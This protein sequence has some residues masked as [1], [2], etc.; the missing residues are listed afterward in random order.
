MPRNHD[1]KLAYIL[2]FAAILVAAN[3]FAI[4]QTAPLL[5]LSASPEL[6][7]AGDTIKITAEPTNFT[8]TST[9]FTWFKNDERLTAASGLGKNTL[10]VATDPDGA[11]LIR[12]RLEVNPGKGF[13]SGTEAL[14][15]YT[16]APPSPGNDIIGGIASDFTLEASNQSPDVGE[17][18]SAEVITFAFDKNAANYQWYINGA[19]DRAQSG[20]GRFRISLAAPAEGAA[21]TVRVDVTAPGG[22]TRSKSVIVQTASAPFYWWAD[23][24]TPYWYKG[25]ALP[26]IGGLVTVMALPNVRGP[27]QLSYQWQIND[28]IASQVSGAGRQT[29]SFRLAVPVEE[30]IGVRMRDLAGAFDKTVSLGVGPVDPIAGIYELRPL[31]GIAYE[32]LLREFSASSGEPHEFIAVPFFFPRTASL[33]YRWNLNGK[34]I[35]GEPPDPWRFILTSSPNTPA[36]DGLS[37]ITEDAAQRSRRASAAATIRLR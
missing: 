32:A 27:A 19:L 31:R 3:W 8:A 25:K 10:L 24:T 6:P 12:I 7:I 15:I 22:E 34:E 21:K 18:V 2:A 11:E 33:I 1:T 23:T 26:S 5:T 4:A 17:A 20:R 36:V 16:L 14:N 35:I 29:Y 37:I 13:A 9:N 30:K 28:S